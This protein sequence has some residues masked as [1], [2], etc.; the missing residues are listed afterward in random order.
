MLRLAAGQSR[1]S[2]C[3]DPQKPPKASQA[4]KTSSLENLPIAHMP[5]R[6]FLRGGCSSDGGGE[7]S[8]RVLCLDKV[9]LSMLGDRLR[10]R[11]SSSLLHCSDNS[12]AAR[13]SED[14]AVAAVK[15]PGC[16]TSVLTGIWNG[17]TCPRI[18]QWHSSDSEPLPV[19]LS[20]GESEGIE[21][22]STPSMPNISPKVD[23]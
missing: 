3:I 14:S 11:A 8:C 15:L 20:S 10:F 13:P 19:E 12:I 2:D 18:L 23:A 9:G 21:E 22:V 5:Y 17:L 4:S 1:I 6:A 16:A 7:I